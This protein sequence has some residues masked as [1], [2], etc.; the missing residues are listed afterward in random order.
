GLSLEGAERLGQLDDLNAGIRLVAPLVLSAFVY[1]LE[2]RAPLTPN[3]EVAEALWVPVPALLDPARHVGDRYR[4]RRWAGGC[5]GDL[6]RH[7][8][9]GLTYRLLEALFGV[10]GARFPDRAP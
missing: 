3:H 6:D 4:P 5:G 1:R 2:G 7:V 8:V 9:W 10:V